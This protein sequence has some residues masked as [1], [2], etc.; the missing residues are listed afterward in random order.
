MCSTL[1][2]GSP[3]YLFLLA[4]TSMAVLTSAPNASAQVKS[5]DVTEYVSEDQIKK[6]GDAEDTLDATLASSASVS[7]VSNHDVVGE[8]DGFSS[9][10]SLG[11]T[12]G[13]AYV[14]GAHLWQN[15]LTANESWART[16]ALEQF[17]KNNDSLQYESLYSYFLLEWFGPFARFNLETSL[18][19]TQLV[20]AEAKDYEIDRTDGT[21]DTLTGVREVA[22]ASSFEPLTLDQSVGLFAEAV[23]STPITWKVRIGAGARETFADGVLAVRDDDSTDVV[24]LVELADVY[25]GGLEAFTGVE[26]KLGGG[27]FTYRAGASALVPFLNN[28]PEDRTA[29]ELLRWGLHAGLEMGIVEWLSLNYKLNVLKDPQ[30]LDVAQV[31]NNLLL[32]F[33]YT[34][35]EPDEGPQPTPAEKVKSLRKE[36]EEAEA[37]A[38]EL[39]AKAKALETKASSEKKSD[40]AAKEGSSES[41]EDGQSQ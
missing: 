7:L 3:I 36:A 13:L 15:T 5:E 19:D 40:E 10:L 11:V 18:F 25:Q 6:S 30:L 17:V 29:I 22:L 32:T 12:G 20:T 21:T 16:P 33:N 8:V 39:R 26:G 24:E 34:L 23:R 9:L 37:K 28:D 1:E 31:Q 14:N 41:A 35:I 38:A 27:K 2:R 4:A